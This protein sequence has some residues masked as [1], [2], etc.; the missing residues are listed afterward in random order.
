MYKYRIAKIQILFQIQIHDDIRLAVGVV[1]KV[2]LFDLAMKTI[3]ITNE[4]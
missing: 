1:L 3:F 2:L 4:K